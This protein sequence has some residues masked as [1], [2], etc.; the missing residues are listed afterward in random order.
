MNSYKSKKATPDTTR[1]NKM[2][3]GVSSDNYIVIKSENDINEN[4]NELK[5]NILNKSFDTQDLD[6]YIKRTILDIRNVIPN[7][8]NKTEWLTCKDDCFKIISKHI[9]L[10]INSTAYILRALAFSIVSF[11]DNSDSIQIIYTGND[12][13]SSLTGKWEKDQP[14]FKIIVKQTN[15]VGKLIM[16]LGPSSS[17]KTYWAKTIIKL[18]NENLDNFPDTFLSIDGGIHRE[19]SFVYQSVI[20]ILKKMN[21]SGLSNLVSAGIKSAII[22]SLFDSNKTKKIIKEFL[23]NQVSPINLYVP[24][25]LGECLFTDDSCFHKYIKPY[26][27]ITGD[28]NWTALHIYQHVTGEKCIYPEEYKCVGTTESGKLRE[29][30]EGKKYSSS[31]YKNSFNSSNHMMNKTDGI[32]LIIHNSGGK[33]T[34][35]KFNKSIIINKSALDPFDNID[36]DNIGKKYNFIY[37]NDEKFLLD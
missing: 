17:G 31:A 30:T 8:N 15:N 37:T 26:V 10:E 32:R 24:E 36:M 16:G 12:N 21:I 7:T 20:Y 11:K 5:Q 28:K 27:E 29:I 4:L 19:S 13:G 23:K 9:D 35:D 25:T 3:G 2:Y 22:G 18:L 6:N 33:K 34:G 14:F 1:R